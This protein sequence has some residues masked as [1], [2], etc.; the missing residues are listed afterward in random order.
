MT[1]LVKNRAPIFPEHR[2]SYPKGFKLLKMGYHVC[3]ALV[4]AR[5]I[6]CTCFKLAQLNICGY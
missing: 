4:K 5:G 6:G 1:P 2:V 3:S